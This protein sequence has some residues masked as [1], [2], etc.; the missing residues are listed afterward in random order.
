MINKCL[1][2]LSPQTFTYLYKCIVR[3][4]LEYGNIIWGPN[5]K[6]DE[7][8]IEKVQR[9]ATR[10]TPSI[11]HLS[12]EERLRMSQPTNYLRLHRDM[13]MTYTP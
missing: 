1:I 10:M 8:D 9:Y 13:L 2:N 12:Y 6:K 5:Y 3:P 11:K 4:Y 7:D